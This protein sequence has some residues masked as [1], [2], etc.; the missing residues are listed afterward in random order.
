MEKIL[1]IYK[2]KGPSSN[3][4]LEEIRKVVGIK[5]VGH[6]GTLDPLARGVLVVA[7]GRK[8]TKKLAKIFSKEKEYIAKIK[9]GWQSTTDDQEGKKIKI[10]VSEIPSVRKIEKILNSFKGKISQIPPS[11]SAVKVKGKEAYKLAREGKFPLLKARKVEIQ[12]IEIL[13]YQWPYLKLKVV[14]GPGVYIRA[15]ARDIGRKLKTGAYLVELE[16]IRVG[17]FTKEKTLSIDQIKQIFQNK[18]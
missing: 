8:A 13:A 6:A 11:F 17:N 7:I 15:L 18:K 12:A 2:P 5:K 1:A 9:L 4:I 14:T 10:K 3:Q 16:R